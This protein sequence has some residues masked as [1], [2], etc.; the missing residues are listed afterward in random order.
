MR[1]LLPFLALAVCTACGTGV[2]NHQIEVTIND[3]SRRLGPAPVE[4]SIF[5]KTSGSS[6]EWARKTMGTAGPGAPYTGTVGATDTKMIFDRT[7][8]AMLDAGLALPALERDGFFVLD[9]K[10]VEGVEQT[11]AMNYRSYGVPTRD[12]DTILPLPAHFRSQGSSKGWTIHLTVD[13][14]PAGDKKP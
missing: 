5:N 1:H 2:Y 14:P 7:P 12:E 9:I 6:E 10:P 3:P 13:V 11:T 4:V 8:P